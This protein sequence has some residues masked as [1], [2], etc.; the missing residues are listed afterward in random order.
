MNAVKPSAEPR[1]LH[2]SERTSG[3]VRR[4]GTV[5]ALMLA[6]HAMAAP[7]TW[8]AGNGNWNVN[9]NWDPGTGYPNAPGDEVSFSGAA[10]TISL[11]QATVT[12]GVLNFTPTS[13][14][15][16]GIVVAPNGAGQTLVLDNGASPAVVNGLGGAFSH[17]TIESPIQL[18]N[19]LIITN[20][21]K[22]SG[23]AIQL[24]APVTGSGPIRVD[25]G[26]LAFAPLS[27][28]VTQGLD[29]ADGAGSLQKK[30]A[31]ELVLTGSG[32]VRLLGGYQNTI[33]GGVPVVISG[34]AITNTAPST[35]T[36]WQFFGGSGNALVVTNGGRFVHAA[37]GGAYYNASGNRIVVTG[38]DS[39]FVA[40]ALTLSANVNQLVVAEGARYVQGAGV[41]RMT[42]SSNLVWVGS[43][44]ATPSVLDLDTRSLYVNEGTPSTANRLVVE[45]GG[46]VTNGAIFFGVSNPYSIGHGLVITNGGQVHA[47]GGVGHFDV[48]HNHSYSNSVLISGAGSL[49]NGRASTFYIA[50]MEG[51]ANTT[52]RWNV[53]TIERGGILTNCA[54]SIGLT[55]PFDATHGHTAL[56]NAVNVANGGRVYSSGDCVIG[57]CNSYGTPL[58]QTVVSNSVAVAGGVDGDSLFHLGNKHLYIGYQRTANRG[59]TQGNALRVGR[60]GTVTAINALYVGSANSTLNELALE[61]GAV[62]ATSLTLYAGNALAPVIDAQGVT[63]ATVTGN[64][65]LQAGSLVRPAATEEAPAG[66]YEILTVAGTLTNSGVVLDPAADSAQW[67]LSVEDKTLKLTYSPPGPPETLILVR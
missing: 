5:F 27:G 55:R 39:L 21:L 13:W 23:Y 51:G 56:E 49:W 29:F 54:I 48:Y 52:G 50:H 65:T 47:T 43:S 64:A 35:T 40:R 60:G 62:T 46:V 31:G 16:N 66:T 37:N 2:P 7:Y 58:N 4:A 36:H 17:S 53:A 9:G 33:E 10:K 14:Q 19:G 24:R 57:H 41:V 11:N 1:R 22:D 45:A 26:T 3:I 34:G 12:T 15:G 59:T 30:G 25:K 8:T 61:G 6:P 44:T 28:S 63:A 32:G 67:E 42:G 18:A 20:S 38:D